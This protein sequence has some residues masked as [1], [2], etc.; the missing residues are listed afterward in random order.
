MDGIEGR[1]VGSG[2]K[3]VEEGDAGI[4]VFF[5]EAVVKAQG[6]VEEWNPECS[7]AGPVEE[8]VER[9]G[10]DDME[11]GCGVSKGEEFAEG[12]PQAMVFEPEEVEPEEV[13]VLGGEG[14]GGT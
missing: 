9:G 8:E 5:V 12:S 13:R 14:G 2:V 6:L 1:G 10:V 7:L 4:E 11:V 3:P